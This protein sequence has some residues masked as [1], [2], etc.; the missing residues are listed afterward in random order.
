MILGIDIGGAN[1]KVASSD[2]RF[3]DIRYLPLW[4]RSPLDEYLLELRDLEPEAVG[5][6]MT[7]ELADC[8]QSK[9]EGVL[10]ITSSA[11]R[12]FG[13]D[14]YFWGLNGFCSSVSQETALDLAAANWSASATLIARDFG[15]CIFVDMGSTTTDI[16][17]IKDRPLAA[18]TDL[19]RLIRG[20]LIYTGLLRT[21]LAALLPS[22]KIAGGVA[23]LSSELF[24][25]TADVYLALG[26]IE[27]G[28]YSCE[29]PDNG[30]KIQEGALRRLARTVCSDLDEIGEKGAMSIARQAKAH[31]ISI[32]ADGISRIS[33]RHGIKRVVA[34]GIGEFV[35][36]EACKHAGLECIRLSA[37]YDH[38]IS[39]VFPAFAVARLLQLKEGCHVQDTGRE[40]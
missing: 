5:V 7:G 11:K 36:E 23:R 25:I 37:I 2:G 33:Q 12:V 10:S 30:P 32:I 17:P 3:V 15:E 13:C 14:V 22:V 38:K 40:P 28:D 31:Q 4:K 6:V 26:D 1:T 8:F 16:I 24:S 35:V 34:A 39:I 9:R 21:N 29:T 18:H 19:Q 20:E 27:E